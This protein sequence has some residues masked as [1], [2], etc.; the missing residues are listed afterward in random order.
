M[1]VLSMLAPRNACLA[2]KKIHL[3]KLNE[4]SAASRRLSTFNVDVKCPLQIMLVISIS[5]SQ[6]ATSSPGSKCRRQHG[7]TV[8]GSINFV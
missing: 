6:L 2:A 5:Y 3:A 4:R 8:S 1:S 7:Q